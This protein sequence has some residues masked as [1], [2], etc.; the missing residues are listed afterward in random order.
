MRTAFRIPASSCAWE[1]PGGRSGILPSFFKVTHYRPSR[2]IDSCPQVA[3]KEQKQNRSVV[4]R[5]AKGLSIVAGGAAS[6]RSGPARFPSSSPRAGRALEHA[7]AAQPH[8]VRSVRRD[9]ARF[10]LGR[11][12]AGWD[13]P[14][15][16]GAVDPGADGD[17][18][19]GAGLPAG[20]RACRNP[21]RRGPRC[22]QRAVGNGGGGKMLGPLRR[23]RRAVW[24]PGGARLHRDSAAGG[25]IGAESGAVLAGARGRQRQP[26]RRADALAHR[27]RAVACQPARLARA[28]AAGLGCRAVPCAWGSARPLEHRA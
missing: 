14:V 21:P 26:Q 9:P 10:G 17:P 13:R 5:V 6:A 4:S 20:A 3:G 7:R 24:R 23:D 19:I 28:G 12:P 16:A 18:R 22:P 8:P 25:R 27:Q 11:L 15:E 2:A 1:S